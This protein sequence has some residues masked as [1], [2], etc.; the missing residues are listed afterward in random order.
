MTLA[1]IAGVSLLSDLCCRLA[2]KPSLDAI[3]DDLE[4]IRRLAF[5][6][7]GALDGCDI[8]QHGSI[9]DSARWL[10][11]EINRREAQLYKRVIG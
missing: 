10:A 2:E 9:A 11:G 1:T 4:A 5:A 3:E 7:E 8:E 6:I